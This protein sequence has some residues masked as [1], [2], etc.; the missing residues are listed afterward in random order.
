MLILLSGAGSMWKW[1]VLQV[2]QRN[3]PPPL[4]MEAMCFPEMLAIQ[5]SFTWFQH[6]K[7]DKQ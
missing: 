4:M 2:F 6:P 5:P 3:I 7:Q 1:F